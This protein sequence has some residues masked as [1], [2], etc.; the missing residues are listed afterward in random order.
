MEHGQIEALRLADDLGEARAMGRSVDQLAVLHQG[1]G[2]GEPGR[3]PERADLP[4][5]LIARAGAAV[6]AVEGGSLQ[7]EGT[8]HGIRSLAG[9]IRAAEAYRRGSG[10]RRGLP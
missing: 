7:E 5:R 6:E 3:V 9:Q 10:F 1:R 8:H 2:L 4:L